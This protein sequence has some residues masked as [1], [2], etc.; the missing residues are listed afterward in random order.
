[1]RGPTVNQDF[2]YVDID[3]HELRERM[4]NGNA[5]VIDVRESFEFDMGH[6]PGAKPMPLST[7][8]DNL[9][10]IPDGAIFVC[11]SGNRSGQA[12]AWLAQQGKTGLAN[13]AGGT[14]AWVMEGL[15]VE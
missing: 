13:L 14:Q 4:E 15:D 12:C 9:D 5:T 2:D 10:D 3:V 6:I 1:M 8:P 7:V 11:A